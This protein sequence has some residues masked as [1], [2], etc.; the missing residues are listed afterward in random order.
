MTAIENNLFCLQKVQLLLTF[1]TYTLTHSKGVMANCADLYQMM[2]N[3]MF[4]QDLSWL[5]I[6]QLFF[7]RN[8]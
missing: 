4:D 3:A 2:Q 5:Q 8:T 7:P 6:A 1:F